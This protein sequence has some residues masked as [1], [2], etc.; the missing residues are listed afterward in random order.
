MPHQGR[1][2]L[3]RTERLVLTGAEVFAVADSIAPRYRLFVLLAVVT[4][5]RR[6]VTASSSSAGKSTARTLAADL[7]ALP[8]SRSSCSSA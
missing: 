7:G 6:C 8:Q 4:C 2:P 1:G 3:L 5:S